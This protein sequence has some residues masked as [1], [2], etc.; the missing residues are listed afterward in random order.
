[1][2]ADQSDSLKVLT[3]SR[4]LILV[5]KSLMNQ[6][7]NISLRV[8]V[9]SFLRFESKILSESRDKNKTFYLTGCTFKLLTD[10]SSM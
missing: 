3:D 10:G 8:L 2:V 4:N 1:M 6:Q 9:N 5:S 7:A